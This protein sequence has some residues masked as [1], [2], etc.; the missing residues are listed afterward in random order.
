[1][2][3]EGIVL[4]HKV[5]GAGLE[6]DNA[7]IDVISNLPPPTNVKGIRSFLRH[8]LLL[9]EFDIEI[10]VKKG[11]KNVT[12]NHLSQ[13]EKDETSDD[14][15]VDDNLPGETLMEISTRDIPWFADFA[16]YWVGDIIPKGMTYQ[17]KNKFFSDLK[18][19]FWEDPYLF[20]VCS[21]G[22]IRRCVLYVMFT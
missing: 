16:N 1:M 14:N 2:V 12:V 19:Y 20:K 22:M 5:S 13:I 8:I 18:Y 11:T 3:K 15:E 10:K 9:Q 6:V 7:K 17:Q 21:D 4:G